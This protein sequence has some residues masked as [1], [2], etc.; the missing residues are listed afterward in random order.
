MPTRVEVTD[1]DK[2]SSLLQYGTH[3]D[4]K[5]FY[6]KGPGKLW[7]YSQTLDQAGMALPGIKTL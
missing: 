5:T 1:S 3:Y 4:R 7:P 2:R 6:C